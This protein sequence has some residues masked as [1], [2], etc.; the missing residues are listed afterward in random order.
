MEKGRDLSPISA[1]PHL[2]LEALLCGLLWFC[3]LRDEKGFG[4]GLVALKGIMYQV[5]GKHSENPASMTIII[6][7]KHNLE[8]GKVEKVKCKA[9][10]SSRGGREK[11]GNAQRK[12]LP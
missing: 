11:Y 4:L 10:P 9:F 6:C 3:Q 5:P 12:A 8:R 7:L 2:L 1:K